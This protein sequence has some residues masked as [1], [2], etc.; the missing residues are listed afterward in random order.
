M[1]PLPRNFL[2]QIAREYDLSLEQEE[3]FVERFSRNK[4]EYEL[5]ESI[6]ISKS[7]FRTRMSGV[8]KKFSIGGFGPGKSRRLH[9]LLLKKY[10]QDNSSPL[11]QTKEV[12]IDSLVTI[13][14]EKIKGD[15]E[16][17]CGK[18][19]VL[20]MTQAVDLESIYTEVNILEQISSRQ[21]IT[22]EELS[23]T[24][25]LCLENFERFGLGNISQE[26]VSG[27]EAILTNRRLMIWGKPG[28]GKTTFLKYLAV[29]CIRETLLSK[30]VP[31]FVTLKDFSESNDEPNLLTY[32]SQ[33]LANCGITETEKNEILKQNRALILLDGLDEVSTEDSRR[34]IREIQIF[35]NQYRT[36][37][38]AITCRIAAKEYTFQ[39]FTEVE[40]ADFD[41]QQIEYFA[42][43]WFQKDAVKAE[44]FITK[45]EENEPIKELATNPLLLTLLCL[46]FGEVGNFP[47]NRGELY[48]EGV[49]VLLKK[50][51]AKRNI[52]RDKVY[53]KLSLKRKE[54]L[55]SNI[56][57]TTFNNQDYFFKQRTVANYIA[58]YIKNLPDAKTDPQALLVDSNAVLKSIESQHGLLVER[59]KG[60]YSF[61]HLT[62]QEYFTARKIVESR[63]IESLKDLVSHITEKRWREVFLL[64]A[65]IME[66]ASDLMVLMKQEVDSLVAEDD[67]IQEFLVWVRD[68]SNSVEHEYKPEYKIAAVRAFYFSLCISYEFFLCFKLNLFI[69][70]F[71]L[72]QNLHRKS[73]FDVSLMIDQKLNEIIVIDLEPINKLGENFD[74]YKTTFFELEKIGFDPEKHSIKGA[75]DKIIFL[76]PNLNQNF[77]EALQHLKN[78]IPDPRNEEKHQQWWEVNDQTWR[79]KLRTVMIKYR[80][81]SHDWQ[82]SQE[83]IELLEKYE[84]ANELL[85][86][87][88]E[89]DC[90]VTKEVRQEIED[91]LLLP[92]ADIRS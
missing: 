41:K 7:A 20:D 89:S 56:A 62:F 18:M 86:K 1:Q 2:T 17:R 47:T 91:T 64:V 61:S 75:L 63:D 82:F 6:N 12:D 48:E 32:I 3:A 11:P 65:V 77:K 45:L 40:V 10:Q 67:K 76:D 28:A 73:D 46:V 74:F 37:Y 24:F 34:I 68:K 81:I 50:W 27:L 52:E 29:S 92:I 43:K 31:I 49:D 70:S 59:A 71:D 53:Q 16:E 84:N 78:Q 54:N 5:A 58:D 60:I 55:L 21:R 23:N 15:I 85:I 19:Q 90:Y 36:H 8:Y 26:R 72:D 88:L 66:D 51:D 30:R 25:N 35:A 4:Q 39:G 44:R 83:Q 87:C 80:N 14:R 79:E 9:D 42:N 57:F 69:F 13:V 22:I 38:F 33:H